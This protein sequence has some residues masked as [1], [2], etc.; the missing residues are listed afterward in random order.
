MCAVVVLASSQWGWLTTLRLC[1]GVGRAGVQ[2]HRN[3]MRGAPLSV[4][5]IMGM[6]LKEV[7]SRASLTN[8]AEDVEGFDPKVAL[9]PDIS[10]TTSQADAS[11]P[12]VLDKCATPVF[13]HDGTAPVNNAAASTA[14]PATAG[15]PALMS[16]ARSARQHRCL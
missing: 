12:G 2:R 10:S 9:P 7:K 15:W 3:W 13:L 5:R 11:H 8:P 16:K 4:D 6:T 14:C 1:P